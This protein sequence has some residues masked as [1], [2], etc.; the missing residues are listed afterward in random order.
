MVRA[1]GLHG[2]E[3][4][5]DPWSGNQVPAC[6]VWSGQKVEKKKRRSLARAGVGGRRFLEFCIGSAP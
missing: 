5:F 3:Y 1:P 2:R 6:G 4:R